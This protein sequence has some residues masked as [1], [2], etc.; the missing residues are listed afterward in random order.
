MAGDLKSKRAVQD[1]SWPK[2]PLTRGT[3]CES[4]ASLSIAAELF[5]GGG[6][7]VGCC[8]H[9]YGKNDLRCAQGAAG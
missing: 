5:G 6:R 8:T 2:P 1:T 9:F 3:F 4:V 7:F